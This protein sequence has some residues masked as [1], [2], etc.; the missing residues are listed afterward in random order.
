MVWHALPAFQSQTFIF[1]LLILSSQPSTRLTAHDA[2]RTRCFDPHLIKKRQKHLFP[3]PLIIYLNIAA[4]C[5]CSR[6][7]RTLY[8]LVWA[9]GFTFKL[10]LYMKTGQRLRV[11]TRKLIVNRKQE[12]FILH[13]LPPTSMHWYSYSVILPLSSTST[14]CSCSTMLIMQ[15]H[16]TINNLIYEINAY[17]FFSLRAEKTPKVHVLKRQGDY[18]STKQIREDKMILYKLLSRHQRD[19]STLNTTSSPGWNSFPFRFNLLFVCADIHRTPLN[20]DFCCESEKTNKSLNGDGVKVDGKRRLLIGG[21]IESERG[22]RG[23][24]NCNF[25]PSVWAA[26]VCLC[27]CVTV[28][29]SLRA[30]SHTPGSQKAVPGAQSVT[31]SLMQQNSITNVFNKKYHTNIKKPFRR[32]EPVRSI[33]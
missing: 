21:K 14:S 31:A 4:A 11:N 5:R 2:G 9:S 17:Y 10:N 29:V 12:D 19:R 8:V 7:K 32:E 23:S 3:V 16:V 33:H 15:W 6:T 1:E 30:N 27:E 18:T 26:C 13:F 24:C 25:Y 20:E 22:R 28:C